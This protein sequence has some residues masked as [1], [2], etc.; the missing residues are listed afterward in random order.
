MVTVNNTINDIVTTSGSN[1]ATS[2]TKSLG[3]D[4]FLKMLVAQLK[5][6]DPL[7]PMDGTEFAAQLAQFSSLEQ[8]THMNARLEALG[9]AN[10]TQAVSLL[11]KEVTVNQGSEFQVEGDTAGFGYSLAKDAAQVSIRILDASGTEVDRIEAGAQSA[12]L[13]NVVWS[14]GDHGSGL[15][16][17][18]VTAVDGEGNAVGVTSMT[19]GR[20]TA[21]QYKDNSIYLKINGQEV[22][23]SDVVAVRNG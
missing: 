16:S 18:K 12:G 6:Q 22:P 11:G 10:N 21:V 8:L 3:K 23:F 14:R 5:N 20:V 15:Y 19:T 13:Q 7:N 1:G 2:H 4:D 17:Y 9:T